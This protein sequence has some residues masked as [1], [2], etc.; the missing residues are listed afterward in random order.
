MKLGFAGFWYNFGFWCTPF[1]MT[2]T[3]DTLDLGY[4]GRT[5]IWVFGFRIASIVRTNPWD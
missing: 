5:E 4:I 2:N 1:A 3:K